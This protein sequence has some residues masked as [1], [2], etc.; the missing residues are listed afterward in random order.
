MSLRE[1]RPSD[2]LVKCA[3]SKFTV[4][5]WNIFSC[6]LLQRICASFEVV[7]FLSLFGKWFERVSFQ[8]IKWFCAQLG[9]LTAL[10]QMAS[11]C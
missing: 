3:L 7:L 4:Q 6:P 9:Y 10:A 2:T 5:W 1:K 8:G 11:F